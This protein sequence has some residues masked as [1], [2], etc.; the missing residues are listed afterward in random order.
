MILVIGTTLGRVLFALDLRG[1]HLSVQD[2][3]SYLVVQGYCSTLEVNCQH[4]GTPVWV[5]FGS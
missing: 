4:K 2:L 3:N 5:L 1:I